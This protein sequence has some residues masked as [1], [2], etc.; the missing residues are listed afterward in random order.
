MRYVLA[1]WAAPLALFWGWYFLSLNDMN[2]G[3]LMLSREVHDFAFQ[4]YGQI[5]GIDPAEIPVLIF[6]ACLFDTLIIAAIWAFRRR[7]EIAGWWQERGPDRQAL[8]AAP[9]AGRALPGE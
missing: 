5:L 4:V 7:R 2:F 8:S 3:Y 1:L 6:R 9:E